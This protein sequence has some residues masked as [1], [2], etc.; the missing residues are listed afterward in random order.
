MSPDIKEPDIKDIR[1]KLYE[2]INEDISRPL[3]LPEYSKNIQALSTY[4]TNYD[5]QQLIK[6]NRIL[7]VFTVILA[8]ATVSLA[9]ITYLKSCV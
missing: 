1:N 5:T 6:W 7:A 4:L 3:N 8:I 9:I 2:C